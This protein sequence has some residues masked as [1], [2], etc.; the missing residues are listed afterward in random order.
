MEYCLGTSKKQRK[1]AK[2]KATPLKPNRVWY[3]PLFD[4]IYVWDY[5]PLPDKF[6]PE[7]CVFLGFL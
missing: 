4:V 7:C 1:E 6:A 2:P 5:K 3:C